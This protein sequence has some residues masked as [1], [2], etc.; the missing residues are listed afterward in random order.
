MAIPHHTASETGPIDVSLLPEVLVND[1]IRHSRQL[2]QELHAG[3][4]YDEACGINYFDGHLVPV[5]EIGEMLCRMTGESRL[6]VSSLWLHDSV[7]DVEGVTIEYLH[8]RGVI[9]PVL[10]DVDLMTRMR[11]ET[12]RHY[13][14]RVSST[15]RSAL[16]KLADSTGNV[17]N[18]LEFH[19]H[20]P[21]WISRK[22]IVKY[23]ANIAHLAPIVFGEEVELDEEIRE[24]AKDPGAAFDA[25]V[26]SL[27]SLR[28]TVAFDDGAPDEEVKLRLL[29]YPRQ[30][31]HLAPVVLPETIDYAPIINEI[32]DAVRL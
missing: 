26:G 16:E 24:A 22:R 1:S 32:A 6:A 8:G 27:C 10:A 2:A 4:W 12:R 11:N 7:E 5:A 19:P 21:A 29:T 25:L 23:P 13:L 31:A 30:V 14:Q 20:F 28:D 17:R 9:S 18:N 15:P 3:K